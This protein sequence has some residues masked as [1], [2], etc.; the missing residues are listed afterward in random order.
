MT[1]KLLPIHQ[2][3]D[4]LHTRLLAVESS[5]SSMD[6]DKSIAVASS[7]F[8]HLCDDI[9]RR[10]ELKLDASDLELNDNLIALQIIED[11][12]REIQHELMEKANS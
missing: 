6:A 8:P 2:R 12:M 7:A 3:M 5:C 11:V 1:D 9:V 4:E 10:V